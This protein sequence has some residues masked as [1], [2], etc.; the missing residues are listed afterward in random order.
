MD[1]SESDLGQTTSAVEKFV[2]PRGKCRSFLIVNPDIGEPKSITI[3]V[4]SMALLYLNWNAITA[5]TAYF[6][7]V[8]TSIILSMS[9]KRM[10]PLWE[11]A[12]LAMILVKISIV[13]TFDSNAIKRLVFASH[14]KLL[15]NVK[16]SCNL[17]KS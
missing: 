11:Q 15:K 7:L 6:E 12:C 1:D 3:E 4:R 13:Q 17:E 2:F 16:L 10:W 8:T 5:Y 9:W 14:V